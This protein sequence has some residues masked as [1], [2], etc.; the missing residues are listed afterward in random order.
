[1]QR[2]T[3]RHGRQW[4]I[5]VNVA[6]I[7]RVRD[8]VGVDLFEPGE[9]D[10]PLIVRLHEPELFCDVLYAVCQPQARAAG[11]ASEQFGEALGGDTIYAAR[12]TFFDEYHTFFAQLHQ[13]EEA[14]MV[15]RVREFFDTVIAAG[16]EAIA[17]LL[18]EASPAEAVAGQV[19]QSEARSGEKAAQ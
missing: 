18:R 3:D 6:S 5:S 16:A 13:P 4:E 10:P 15:A 17:D 11:V 9:G 19:A 7:R 2:F 8:L 12:K 14:A 1:M